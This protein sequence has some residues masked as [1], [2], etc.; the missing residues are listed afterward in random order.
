M[1]IV[2]ELGQVVHQQILPRY[3]SFQKINVS[4]FASGGY[5]VFIRCGTRTV[6]VGRFVKEL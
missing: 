4:G 2:N 3:S 5:H 6:A 1:E